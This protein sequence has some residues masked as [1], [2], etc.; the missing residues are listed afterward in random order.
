MS[1]RA[2]RGISLRESRS[3]SPPLTRII[4]ISSF[5][6]SSD[7]V[8]SIGVP[9]LPLV[10]VPRIEIGYYVPQNARGQALASPLMTDPCR[11]QFS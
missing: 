10:A 3:L 11:W 5:T 6:T 9:K 8:V 7:Y 1:S 2:S 4:H